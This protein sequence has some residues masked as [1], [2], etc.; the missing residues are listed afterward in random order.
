MIGGIIAVIAVVVIICVI[1]TAV[2]Q[3]AISHFYE[4]Y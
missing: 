2:T 3:S 1:G 4:T